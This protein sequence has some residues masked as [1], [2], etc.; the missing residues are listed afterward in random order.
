MVAARGGHVEIV[1]VLIKAGADVNFKNC[2]SCSSR[3]C[4]CISILLWSVIE[5]GDCPY[6]GC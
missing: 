5:S 4:A 1:Q 6:G 2:V 3:Q